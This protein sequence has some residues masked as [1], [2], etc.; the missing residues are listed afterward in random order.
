[1]VASAT[2]FS[3][4]PSNADA[5]FF[6][7]SQ[8][9]D[10]QTI[11]IL[12]QVAVGIGF[13]AFIIGALFWKIVGLETMNI[14]QMLFF[15]VGLMPTLLPMF[16]PIAELNAVNGYNGMFK[17]HTDLFD[18][19]EPSLPKTLVQMKIGARFIENYNY[20]LIGN[21]IVIAIGGIFFLMS[22][23]N[24]Y[25]KRCMLEISKFFMADVLNQLVIFNSL[26][27]GFSFGLHMLY[28]NKPNPQPASNQAACLLTAITDLVVTG[29]S[30]YMV[31]KKK[32]II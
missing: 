27:V 25:T 24:K 13:T 12:L 7:E 2:T 22:Y 3:V 32:S 18:F 17:D 31:V 26:N 1:M 29:L 19:D 15:C 20:M 14:L 6:D 30:C 16:S 21:L 10:S 8:Y 28:F 4:S 9:S 5:I 23:C 11:S